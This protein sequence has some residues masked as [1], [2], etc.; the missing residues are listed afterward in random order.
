MSSM[1]LCPSPFCPPPIPP[2]WGARVAPLGPTAQCAFPL[3]IV[4]FKNKHDL[5]TALPA[6]PATFFFEGEVYRAVKSTLSD[7]SEYGT[8]RVM[9]IS[10]RPQ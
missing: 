9:R 1:E 7:S 5:S 4:E 8:A 2:A 6:N 10:C 3:G